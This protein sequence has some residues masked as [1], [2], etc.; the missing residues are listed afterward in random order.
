LIESIYGEDMSACK[1]IVS[2]FKLPIDKTTY[3]AAEESIFPVRSGSGFWIGFMIDDNDVP[4]SD[5]QKM[6]VW[7]ATYNTFGVKEDGAY[8]VFE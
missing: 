5:V 2:E 3:E 8:A 7:P 6:L 1:V 4:G